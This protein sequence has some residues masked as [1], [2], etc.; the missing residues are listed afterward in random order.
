MYDHAD[1]V[2]LQHLTLITYESD[3]TYDERYTGQTFQ[4]LIAVLKF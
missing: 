1:V 2:R 3:F 4:R